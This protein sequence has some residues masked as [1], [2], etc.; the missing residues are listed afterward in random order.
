MKTKEPAARQT[1]PLIEHFKAHAPQL[2]IDTRQRAV[3]VIL[4]MTTASSVNVSNL[5]SHL[6]GLC[7]TDT[8]LNSIPPIREKHPNGFHAVQTRIFSYSLRSEK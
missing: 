7:S 3:D 5:T 2:R 1:I 4:A 6:P 8:G